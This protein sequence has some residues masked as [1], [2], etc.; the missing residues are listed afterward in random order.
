MEDLTGKLRYYARLH[1][2]VPEGVNAPGWRALYPAAFPAVL[3]IFTGKDRPVLERRMRTLL[4]R[5][6]Q[7]LEISSVDELVIY[8][9]LLED[10]VNEGPFAPIFLRHDDPS[11][12]ADWLG[13]P[14][15]DASA[16]TSA[17]A[18]ADASGF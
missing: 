14:P 4:G 16:A 8:C 15:T 10:L 11:G 18:S 2:Y 9:A 13:A 3:L 5:L 7:D 12:Y 6:S 17:S 1:R